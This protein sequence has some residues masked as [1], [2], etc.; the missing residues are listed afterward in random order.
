MKTEEMDE[1]N[2]PWWMGTHNHNL[3]LKVGKLTLRSSTVPITLAWVGVKLERTRLC[4]FLRVPHQ[5]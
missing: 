1:L 5:L 4:T 2:I 3:K